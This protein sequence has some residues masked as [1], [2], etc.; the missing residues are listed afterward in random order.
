MLKDLEKLSQA[1]VDLLF[2]LQGAEMQALVDLARVELAYQQQKRALSAA[3]EK[4]A[5]NYAEMAR[6]VVIAHG[7]DPDSYETD[8]ETQRIVPIGSE[9]FNLTK[10]P[11]RESELESRR[12]ATTVKIRQIK[13]TDDEEE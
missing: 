10:G 7:F 6:Q 1:E 8:I 12:G 2:A 3:A 4:A 9:V 5:G 11:S 13:G